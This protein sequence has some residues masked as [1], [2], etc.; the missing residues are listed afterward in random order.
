MVVAM[1]LGL[2][3]AMGIALPCQQPAECSIVVS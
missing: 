2:Q 1:V 3:D